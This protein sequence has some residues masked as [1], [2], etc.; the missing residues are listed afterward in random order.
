MVVHL[1]QTSGRDISRTPL[2]ELLPTCTQDFPQ[3]LAC[4]RHR[5]QAL[6]SV[7]RANSSHVGQH[8]YFM[9]PTGSKTNVAVKSGYQ[10]ECVSVCSC[11]PCET[12]DPRKAVS[13]GSFQGDRIPSVTSAFKKKKRYNISSSQ[14]AITCSSCTPT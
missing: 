10:Q 12:Y 13:S 3:L 1:S 9:C 8:R 11:N 14:T 5:A 6:A 4:H 7:P 2:P